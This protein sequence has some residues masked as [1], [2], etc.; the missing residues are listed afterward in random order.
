MILYW[1]LPKLIFNSDHCFKTPEKPFSLDVQNDYVEAYRSIDPDV[2]ITIEPTIEGALNHAREIGNRDNGMQT[3]V[4]GSL[5]LIGGALRLL[6][7]N[8]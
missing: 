1:I 4:T 7:T 5:Y 6:E 2:H 3:L 8:S